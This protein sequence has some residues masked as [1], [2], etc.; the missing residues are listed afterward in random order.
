MRVLLDGFVMVVLLA[1]IVLL[2][3]VAVIQSQSA[4]CQSQAS[5]QLSKTRVVSFRLICR[6]GRCVAN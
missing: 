2:R 6:R 3:D 4:E 1:P 5:H